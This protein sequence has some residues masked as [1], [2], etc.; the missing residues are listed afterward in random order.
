MKIGIL[1]FGVVGKS[2]LNFLSKKNYEI[3]VWDKRVLLESEIDLI[4]TYQTANYFDSTEISIENFLD[5]HEKVIVSP[6][7]NLSKILNKDFEKFQNKFLCELDFLSD[8]LIKKSIAVTGSLGKTTIVSLLGQFLPNSCIAGNIGTGMLDV[9]SDQEKFDSIVLELSSFQLELNKKFSPDIAILNNLYPNHLDRHKTIQE[10]FDAKCKIFEYQKIGQKL[11]ISTDFLTQDIFLENNNFLQ[12]IFIDK[13]KSIKSDIVFI[14]CNWDQDK[15]LLNNFLKKFDF[16]NCSIFY[17][18]YNFLY[19]E[20]NKIF[21]LNFL[22]NISFKQN[23]LFV[24]TTLYFCGQDFNNL[25]DKLK[26]FAKF[27]SQDFEKI[28]QHRVEFFYAKNN[29]DFYNDS[30][31]TVV[32]ATLQAVNKLNQNNKPIILILGGTGKGVDRSFI[33]QELSKFKNLK[34]ILCLGDVAYKEFEKFNKSL[35]LSPD[36]NSLIHEIKKLAQS[37]DQIL[38]SPS[39]ASFDLFK[40]YKDRGNQFKELIKNLF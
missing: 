23:W 12:N 34:N 29:I 24:L 15:V 2:V 18:Q 16:K 25:E 30:K 10:Y 13:L 1:G 6:G 36:L 11:L 3:G 37:G 28:Q 19:L 7:V 35:I 33:F 26:N 14:S 40:D 4:K 22:P 21:D 39:G 8:F 9:L 20:Q 38:F 17:N 31:S 27:I 5:S 32:Q